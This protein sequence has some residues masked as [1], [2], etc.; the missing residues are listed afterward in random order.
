MK[1][2]ATNNKNNSVKINLSLVLCFISL[3]V[4]AQTKLSIIPLPKT[5]QENKGSFQLSTKTTISYNQPGL[6]KLASFAQAA[7]NEASAVEPVVASVSAKQTD[8]NIFL[9]LD[10]SVPTNAEGYVLDVTPSGISIKAN[11][12]NGLFYGMQTLVQLI[13]VEG[14]KKIPAVHIEDEPRFNWRGMMLD[15][16][17]HKWSVDFIKKFIDQL[18]Y[19]KLN[20]FHWHLTEDQGWRIEIK[21]YP[22]LQEIA[23]YRNGTLCG[24][25]RSEDVDSIRYGGYY[26]QE[27]IKEVVAH[28][29]SRYIEV[30]PEIEMPG[31]SVAAITAYPYLACNEKSFETGKPHEVRKPVDGIYQNGRLF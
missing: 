31:H 28:A 18:A 11:A 16:C 22:K 3:S 10:P 26:I 12:E 29:A 17:R 21:K 4:S 5:L 14:N 8:K 6:Q 7:I 9:Q 25:N 19:H 23:A 20:K 30:I 27:Q 24:P 2:S 1:N 13:P 15:V